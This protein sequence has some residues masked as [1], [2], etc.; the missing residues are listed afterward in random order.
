[1][2]HVSLHYDKLLLDLIAALA[3][4]GLLLQTE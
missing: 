2:V 4:C 1:M 3:G